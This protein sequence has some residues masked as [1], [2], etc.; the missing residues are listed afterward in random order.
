MSASR[1]P[2]TPKISNI[3]VTPSNDSFA[4]SEPLNLYV[5]SETIPQIKKTRDSQKTIMKCRFKSLHLL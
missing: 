3:T 5:I 2:T 4:C 1:I